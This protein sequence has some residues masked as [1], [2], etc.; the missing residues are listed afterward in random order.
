MVPL[1]GSG[2]EGVA[3]KALEIPSSRLDWGPFLTLLMLCRRKPHH[4]RTA[5]RDLTLPRGCVFVVRYC[6]R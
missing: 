5:R 6:S 4:P 2:K 1:P 3:M